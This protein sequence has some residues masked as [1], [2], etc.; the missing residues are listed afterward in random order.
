MPPQVKKSVTLSGI[1]V[2]CFPDGA[3]VPIEPAEMYVDN[4][5]SVNVAYTEKHAA[6]VSPSIR[7]VRNWDWRTKSLVFSLLSLMVSMASIFNVSTRNGG[8]MAS[9]PDP[10]ACSCSFS[11]ATDQWICSYNDTCGGDDKS[12]DNRKFKWPKLGLKR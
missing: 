5:A 4:K 2:P 11:K 6:K 12:R 10:N 1:P 7:R 9:I 3:Y 8:N